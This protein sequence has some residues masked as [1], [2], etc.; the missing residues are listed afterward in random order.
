MF[1]HLYILILTVLLLPVRL[2]GQ[3]VSDSSQITLGYPVYSQ[4]LQNGLMINP[5]YAGSRE[6]LSVTLSYR[7]QWMGTKG[8][9]VLQSVSLHTPMKNDKVA[10]G[11]K[12]RFM[13]YGVT[14]STS[15]FGVYAYQIRLA[16]GKL[17]FGLKA[18]LNMSNNDY[19]GLLGITRPDPVFAEDEKSYLL[20][21]AGFGVYYFNDRFFGGLSIPSFLCYKNAGNGNA[22][23]Y[24]DFKEYEFII[25]AGGLIN[26]S[27]LF[28]IKPSVL[29]NF[30]LQDTKRLNQFDLNGNL[31]IAD[32]IWVGASYRTTEQVVVGLLQFQI[33]QQ[34]MAGL[35][36]DYPAGRMNTYSK[37]SSEFMI[38]YEFGS[39]VSAANPRYF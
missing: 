1:R 9:P 27:P 7:M 13:Q 10:L 39:K 8:A 29:V 2:S 15:L 18:G 20:P 28:R 14:R 38:R 17:S 19:S 35:S 25:N 32:I 5:A 37:G 36:Y 31:I 34:L 16:T 33:T 26:I 6:A 30:S 24:H 23:V 11:F 21:N 3:G 22:Q 12:A 4:Y